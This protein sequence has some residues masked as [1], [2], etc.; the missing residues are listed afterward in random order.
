MKFVILHGSFGSKDGNW[1]PQ[2]K[3]KLELLNQEVILEQFPVD[4]WNKVLE[5]GKKYGP[6]KQNLKDWLMTFEKKIFPRIKDD[7]VVVVAHSLGPLFL[8]HVVEKFSIK[9]DAAI[10]VSPFLYIPPNEKLWPIDL[11]NKSFYKQEFDFK[12]LKERIPLSYVLYADNDPYVPIDKALEF[13]DKLGSAKIP[14]LGGGHLN[15]E[16]NLNEFPLVLELCKSR[17]NLSLYQKYLAFLSE[18]HPSE[19]IK[20]GVG[21]ALLMPASEL[22]KEGVFHFNHLQRGGFC[23]LPVNKMN[24]WK[25]KQSAYM[26]AGRKAARR[27]VKIKRVYIIDKEEDIDR[28]AGLREMMEE[29]KKSGIEVYF[30][31]RKDVS[32]EVR[33]GDFGI[34][35]GDYVCTVYHRKN[36]VEFG[37]DSRESYLSEVNKWQELI[38]RVAKKF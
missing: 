4:D 27:G 12:I 17:I 6:T 38:M 13:A 21:R 1:F 18:Y 16:V 26:K 25:E 24:Y 22:T 3:E 9:I 8:L 36:G 30:C 11:V 33:E 29:D 10:F 23:T 28:I 15:A 19:L 31:L 35:D 37:L 34:W 7:K 14:V 2:L 32:P 5:I 20:K